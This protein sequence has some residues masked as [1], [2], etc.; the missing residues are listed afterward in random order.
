MQVS[1]FVNWL[2]VP[3]THEAEV[4]FQT[5]APPKF[6]HELELNWLQLAATTHVLLE[7]KKQSPLLE[8]YPLHVEFVVKL[9]QD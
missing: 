6:V 8:T 3:E 5:H 9:E 7:L 2:Q 1:L 4:V